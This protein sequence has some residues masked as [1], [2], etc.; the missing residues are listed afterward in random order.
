MKIGPDSARQSAISTSTHDQ[1]VVRGRDLCA[2]LIGKV[3]F[4]EHAWL[5][6]AGNR[7]FCG[8]IKA[9]KRRCLRHCTSATARA[10]AAHNAHTACRFNS[11]VAGAL[12]AALAKP[13][14]ALCCSTT[15]NGSCAGRGKM[16]VSS[17]K[18]MSSQLA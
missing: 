12:T 17:S 1:I 7:P 16:V 5:L 6:A 13:G 3:S 2:D 18:G 8:P 9:S 10:P 15:R 11:L 14:K 4:T